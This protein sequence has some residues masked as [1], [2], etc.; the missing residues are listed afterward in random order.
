VSF[1]PAENG[2]PEVFPKAVHIS[3]ADL[4][5]PTTPVFNE[6]KNVGRTVCSVHKVSA[7][8]LQ[9]HF[10]AL[11]LAPLVE[12]VRH[13]IIEHLLTPWRGAG[14]VFGI[15]ENAAYRQ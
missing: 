3:K 10:L 5:E 8:L 7:Y 1:Y 15:Q 2:Q 14:D 9:G 11:L 13:G 12:M 6:G 4:P